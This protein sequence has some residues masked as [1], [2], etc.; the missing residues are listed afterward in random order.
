VLEIFLVSVLFHQL[1]LPDISYDFFVEIWML[2]E[3]CFFLV[4]IL[5]I[6]TNMVFFLEIDL[7]E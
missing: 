5:A 6:L 4:F 2:F 7:Y 3:K 1:L